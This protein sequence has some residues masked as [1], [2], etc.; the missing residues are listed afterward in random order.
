MQ[1]KFLFS[2]GS[3]SIRFYR[4]SGRKDSNLSFSRSGRKAPKMVSGVSIYEEVKADAGAETRTGT[5]LLQ[6]LVSVSGR[7][8]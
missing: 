1:R 7:G 2:V 8:R 4:E 3:R 5:W 6:G